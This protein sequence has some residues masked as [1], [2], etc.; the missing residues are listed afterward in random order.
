MKLTFRGTLAFLRLAG[1]ALAMGACS[2][3]D[4]TNPAEAPGVARPGLSAAA[5]SSDDLRQQLT[6]MLDDANGGLALAGANYRAALITTIGTPEEQGI[7]VLWRDVG[8]KHLGVDFVP[9]D[10]RRT[11]A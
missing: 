6:Q 1:V 4:L 5:S 11:V 3:D 9:D 8:N 7:T 2:G 10:P